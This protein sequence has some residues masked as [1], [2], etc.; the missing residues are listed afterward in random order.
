M[1]TVL[2]LE[3]QHI[4]MNACTHAADMAS[5]AIQAAAGQYTLPSV[6]FQPRLSIDGDHWCALYGDNLQ[7]G[8]AGFG[9]SPAA[10]M[11]DFDCNWS[12][13]LGAAK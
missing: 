11:W 12:K 2:D 13:T 8:V 3:M 9:K 6:L 7:D 1:S 4:V 5:A 10:A